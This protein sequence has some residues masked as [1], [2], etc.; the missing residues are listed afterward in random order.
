[1]NHIFTTIDKTK[2]N[3]VIMAKK[4]THLAKINPKIKEVI[5]KNLKKW[6]GSI[7]ELQEILERKNYYLLYRIFTELEKQL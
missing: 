3:V 1:M 2:A 4:I 6:S 7:P 5:K